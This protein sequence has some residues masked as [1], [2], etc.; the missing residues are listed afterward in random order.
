[1]KR[2][3][4]KYLVPNGITFTSLAVGLGAILEAAEENLVLAGAMIFISFWLD[5]ADGFTA[6]RLD[7]AS[8]FGLQLDSLVDVICFGAAPAVLVFQHLRIQGGSLGWIVSL[9]IFYAISGA[10][11][12]AR[13]NLLPPKTSSNKDSVGMAITQAGGTVA[14]A[15]LADLLRADGFLPVWGYIPLLLILSVMMVST[16]G[17][18]PVT[19]FVRNRWMGFGILIGASLLILWLSTF[20]SL[21]ILFSIYPLVA[22]IRSIYHRTRK[23]QPA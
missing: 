22:L 17:F 11:R 15:V 7:A 20:A 21:F 16:L 5:M 14:V 19:W 2:A 10:F 12:L 6:R 9:V 4:L 18:P 1:M 8:E 13:F 3:N 23:E